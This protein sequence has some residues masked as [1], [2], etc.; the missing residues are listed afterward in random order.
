MKIIPVLFTLL[1]IYS[2]IFCFSYKFMGAIL[3][4]FE[5]F[6][7]KM[8]EIKRKWKNLKTCISSFS[9]SASPN[10]SPTNIFCLGVKL[11]IP[12]DI[13]HCINF[14]IKHFWVVAFPAYQCIN[15]TSFILKFKFRTIFMQMTK[16]G[17][18]SHL[19]RSCIPCSYIYTNLQKSPRLQL[20]GC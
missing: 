17:F 8:K 1:Y 9:L 16:Y 19:Q 12:N 4:M 2:F 15:T 14:C 20:S 13:S 18:V 3:K 11:Q 5:I 7:E 6:K 10:S